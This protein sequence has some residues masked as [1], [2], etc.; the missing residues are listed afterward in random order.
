[1]RRRT[2]AIA[3]L[4][5]AT[6]LASCGPVVRTTLVSPGA[7]RP[8]ICRE[9]VAVFFDSTAIHRPYVAI[10][11]LQVGWGPDA[12]PSLDRVIEALQDHAG[13]VGATGVIVGA[14]WREIP[15]NAMGPSLAILIAGD[16]LRARQACDRARAGED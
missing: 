8:S 13:K 7:R 3:A 6:G 1:M 10:A 9:G 2:A 15:T 16:T 4:V 5:G 14:G 12:A 11:S